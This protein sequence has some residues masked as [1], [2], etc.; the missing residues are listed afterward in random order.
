MAS[1]MLPCVERARLAVSGPTPLSGSHASLPRLLIITEAA[2]AP[3]AQGASKTLY[4]LF[5]SYPGPLRVVSC[6]HGP[7]D[8]LD[9]VRVPRRILPERLNRLGPAVARTRAA[10]DRWLLDH[11]P[12]LR[13]A[14]R[15]FGPQIVLACPLGGWGIAAA[16]TSARVTRAPLITYFMDDWVGTAA[17]PG[18]AD[19]LGHATRWLMISDQLRDDLVARYALRAPPTLIVH[20][21]A[22]ASSRPR[23]DHAATG[24]RGTWRIVYAGSIWP[25]H[26]D[27]ITLAASAVGLLRERGEDVELVVHTHPRFAR[28]HAA[29]FEQDGVSDGGLL[30]C[31]AAGRGAAGG[32]PRARRLLV[33][34]GPAAH[35]SV[36]RS[37]EADG[38]HERRHPDRRRRPA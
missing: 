3:E 31:A 8:H 12:W 5:S 16:A 20:N 35:V 22:H 1:R 29:I 7:N 27:A 33:C 36:L 6:S 18:A 37:D 11:G 32:R 9:R 15:E 28:L 23:R 38:L 30:E 34:R 4:D 13:G 21:P 19:L 17:A 26:A 14:V 2:V 10:A 25:M 24:S